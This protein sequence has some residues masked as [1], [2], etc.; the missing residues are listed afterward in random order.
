MKKPRDPQR[1]MASRRRR[2]LRKEWNRS[3]AKEPNIARPTFRFPPYLGAILRWALALTILAVLLG[4]VPAYRSARSTAHFLATQ[5]AEL[6]REQMRLEEE[7][8]QLSDPDW[9]ANY[10][11]W[12]TMRHEPGERFISFIP[13]EDA[14]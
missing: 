2:R 1:T 8:R 10:W 14:L 3:R 13:Q 6:E 11:K 12:L 4:S 7:I 5:Q 9:R